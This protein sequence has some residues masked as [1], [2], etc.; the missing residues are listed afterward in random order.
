MFLYA[1]TKEAKYFTK[2]SYVILQK[3][4][5]TVEMYLAGSN[6]EQT[7]V[8]HPLEQL[9]DAISRLE[10]QEEVI[11]NLPEVETPPTDEFINYEESLIHADTSTENLD[12]DTSTS[13]ESEIEQDESKE[14]TQ[15]D[16]K[17]KTID[18]E[19]RVET[20]NDP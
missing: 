1:K 3:T 6:F 15:H 2:Q 7:K 16:N 5:A 17:N 20:M 9:S 4:I 10:N 19:H 12:V 14:T 13:T 8:D 18:D 11:E